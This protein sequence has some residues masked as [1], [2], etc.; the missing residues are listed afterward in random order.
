[1]F[2]RFWKSV[3]ELKNEPARKLFP[4]WLK[5]K[6]RSYYYTASSCDEKLYEY[7]AKVYTTNCNVTL[8]DGKM[9]FECFE[10]PD[11]KKA[12]WIEK[13]ELTWPTCAEEVK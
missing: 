5:K 3:R 10:E 9:L 1:M 8:A 7:F 12:E 6:G 13:S 4:A 2:T 11:S